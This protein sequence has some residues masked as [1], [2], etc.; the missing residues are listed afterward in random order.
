M[1]VAIPAAQKAGIPRERIFLLEGEKEGYTTVK[2]LLDQGKSYGASG[3]VPPFKIPPGQTNKDICG[4]LCFSSG[5]TGLPKAVRGFPSIR[6]WC[7]L[8]LAG[9][10]LASQRNSAMPASPSRNT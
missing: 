4:F 10:D 1:D 2:Q 3:Q 7:V 5:T 6:R 9:H 8:T